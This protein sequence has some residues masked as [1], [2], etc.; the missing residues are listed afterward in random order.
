MACVGARRPSW[1]PDDSDDRP[2][3]TAV[4]HAAAFLEWALANPSIRWTTDAHKRRPT[5]GYGYQSWVRWAISM[6]KSNEDRVAM[7]QSCMPNQMSRCSEQWLHQYRF[8]ILPQ[9]TRRCP[10]HTRSIPSSSDGMEDGQVLAIQH[11]A[12]ATGGI[13]QDTSPDASCFTCAGA[14]EAMI[15]LIK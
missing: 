8:H 11:G 6:D 14:S 4:R 2:H 12:C 7:A 5:Y 3:P 10:T 1:R 9:Y 15:S 13:V